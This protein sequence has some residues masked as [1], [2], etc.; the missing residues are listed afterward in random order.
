MASELHEQR[1][2]AVVRHLL[3][4]GATR[5][6]DL[7]CAAGELLQRLAWH[8]QFTRIV[9]IDIDERALDEARGAL[10]LSPADANAR[11]QVRYGS[12]EE[13]D[14]SLT[15]F[16]AAAMVETLEHID[17]RRLHRVEEAVFG[18]MRPGVVLVTTPNQEYNGL[19]GLAP[20]E[21]RHPGHRFEWTREK[22][23]RWAG[24]VAARQYYRA[25]FFDVG[26]PHPAYGASTQMAQF[27]RASE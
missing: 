18:G 23:R 24:G 10:G 3:V 22:F 12:F 27:I 1:L 9:G 2:E 7:G 21:R 14:R 11:V 4:S 8:P 20:G 19:H 25:E 15:G 5:V 26:P 13:T 16:D 6:L 17:P